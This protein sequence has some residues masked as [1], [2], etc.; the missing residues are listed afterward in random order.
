MKKNPTIEDIKKLNI[1]QLND[2]VFKLGMDKYW[3]QARMRTLQYSDQV[4]KDIAEYCT[5]GRMID[6]LHY[7]YKNA[8]GITR[9]YL[10]IKGLLNEIADR[11]TEDLDLFNVVFLSVIYFLKEY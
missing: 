8:T 7:N 5:I 9:E 1:L 6:I 11:I 3:Q 4:L 10:C 2:L